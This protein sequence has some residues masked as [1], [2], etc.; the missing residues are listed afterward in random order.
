MA[1]FEVWMEGYLATGMEGVP[2]NPEI[3]GTVEQTLFK[4][5]AI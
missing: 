5:L 2:T 3:L 1:K 4:K